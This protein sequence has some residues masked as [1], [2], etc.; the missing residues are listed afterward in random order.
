MDLIFEA[1]EA[2]AYE[3]WLDSPAGR[4]YARASLALVDRVL[5]CRPGWRVLDVGC[6][7]GLHLAHLKER[8]ML[9]QGLEAGPVLARLAGQRLG[10]KVEVEV[11]DAHDLPFED[12]SFDAVILVNTLELVDRRAQVLAE[13]ARVAASRVCLVSFNPFSMTSLA[14]RLFKGIRLPVPGHH[15]PVWSLRRLVR[16]VLGPVPLMWSGA[17]LWPL[18]KVGPW[19]MAGLVGVSAAVTPRFMTRPLLVPAS[20]PA[21]APRPAHSHGR[22]SVLNRSK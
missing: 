6:G 9:C 18:V 13:A 12:N 19:P 4:C 17:T 11:G 21:R 3:T 2:A 22:L 15:L 10:P 16:E 8:G 20:A 14:G 7:L 1:Q 5:D